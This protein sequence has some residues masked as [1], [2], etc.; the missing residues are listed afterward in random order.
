MACPATRRH[1]RNTFS[2][3]ISSRPYQGSAA[4]RERNSLLRWNLLNNDGHVIR[5][6]QLGTAI[7]LPS[8]Y[9]ED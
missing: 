4:E 2:S 3:L 7:P 8:E 6:N 1:R 5:N 9:S